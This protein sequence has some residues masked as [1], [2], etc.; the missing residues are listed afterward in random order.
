MP[1]K[2]GGGFELI[3][4]RMEKLV[5]PGI[6]LA[7]LF[8]SCLLC[9]GCGGGSSSASGPYSSITSGNWSLTAT[10]SVTSGLVLSI[11]GSLTQS[12]NAVSGTMLIS[13][14]VSNCPSLLSVATPLPG[15]L[16]ATR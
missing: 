15:H 12:G 1:P 8:V 2:L 16:G 14:S 11:G 6:I 5:K 7:V 3:K 10:S 13:S 4:L 9:I